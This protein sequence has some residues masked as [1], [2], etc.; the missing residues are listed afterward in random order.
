M[1][2]SCCPAQFF[3]LFF[4]T[5]PKDIWA[6]LGFCSRIACLQR[7]TLRR[8]KSKTLFFARGTDGSPVTPSLQEGPQIRTPHDLDAYPRAMSNRGKSAGGFV[9]AARS[10]RLYGGEK[11]GPVPIFRPR[12]ASASRHA[13][14]LG[15]PHRRCVFSL[16]R[17]GVGMGFGWGSCFENSPVENLTV[18]AANQT[19]TYGFGGSSAGGAGSAEAE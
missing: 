6:A 2:S 19:Q 15:R 8:W 13:A 14:I 9:A 4:L 5:P 11:W 3:P 18:T 7:V 10:R 12:F 1:K 16:R 17:G